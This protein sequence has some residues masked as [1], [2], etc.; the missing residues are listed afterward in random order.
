[1]KKIITLLIFVPIFLSAELDISKVNNALFSIKSSKNLSLPI[2]FYTNSS[3]NFK[4]ELLSTTKS[5]SDIIIFPKSKRVKKASIVDSYG[6]LRKYENSIGAIYIKKGRTQI[7]F[8]K[9]RL[10]KSG[11]KLIKISK[12]YMIDECQLDSNC[13]NIN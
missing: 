4:K 6:A 2:K 1:M 3:L 12:K 9:E 8:V 7:I 5:S 11:F 13:L 10:K